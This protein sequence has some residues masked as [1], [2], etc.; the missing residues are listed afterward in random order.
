MDDTK[1][2][3]KSYGFGS[4]PVGGG[5]VGAWVIWIL[6]IIKFLLPFILVHQPWEL[7]RDE[8]LYYA[9]GQHLALGYLECPPLV[10]WLAY[11]ASVMGGSF[12][13]VKF[14]PSLFGALMVLV[15]ANIVKEMGGKLFAQV[16]AA[17]GIIFSAYLRNNFLL[18][19]VFL[20][21]FFW[22]LSIYYLLRLINTQQI[23]YYYLLGLA[24]TL[25]WYSKYSA[26]FFVC[27]L[28]A[29]LLLTYHRKLLTSKHLWLAAAMTLVLI[30][31]NIY[32]QYQH[33][34]P[35]ARHMQ[36]LRETQ[37]QYISKS[38]F[39]KEQILMLF[40]VSFVWLCG[41]VWLLFSKK[42]CFIAFTYL[43]VIVLLM[44]GSGKG[45]Y[46]LGV[47]PMLLAAGGV[48]LEKIS[49]HRTWLR[50]AFVVIILGLAYPFMYALLPIQSPEAMAAT[51]RKYDLAGKGLTKWEDLKTHPL[52]QDFAD[53]LGWRE[54]ASKTEHSYDSLTAK[55]YRNILVYAGNYGQ[56]GALQYYAKAPGYKER[57]ISQ[58]G[59]FVLWIIPPLRF[60]HIL[61]VNDE[62]PEQGKV[63]FQ[64]FKKI[65]L[66]D[67]V[68]NPLSRQWGDKIFLLENADSTAVKML[69]TVIAEKQKIFS[70]R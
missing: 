28:G 60:S 18:Q 10:G 21:I 33:N 53:M 46:A 44:L 41:L 40:P 54:L 3:S 31:H 51:N 14:W 59:T 16:I 38:D 50:I 11:T 20:E 48:F 67:S 65:T 43:I 25:S 64:H 37:L 8:Y 56:A 19:P 22:T 57:I 42:Y 2:R 55:G 6:A 58:N 26:L 69:N 32:W 61:L 30:L 1:D 29:G 7:H 34:W 24:V 63:L 15:T 47:Y 9:Q 35:L 4:S 23:K 27:G 17:L 52:E 39:L 45:Y 5:W 68:A 36:E 12:F 62:L 13:W 70:R 49:I 66:L